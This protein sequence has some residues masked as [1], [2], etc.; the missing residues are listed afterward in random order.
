MEAD[1]DTSFF[2]PDYL[3]TPQVIGA[4]E[5]IEFLCDEFGSENVYLV[6]K[7]SEATAQRSLEWLTYRRFYSETGFARQNVLFCRSREE[8]ARICNQHAL[9]AFIDDRYSVLQHMLEDTR[10]TKLFLF[11]PQQEELT[12]FRA[13]QPNR[14]QLIDHWFWINAHL[15][16]E[17][18]PPPFPLPPRWRLVKDRTE[19]DTMARQFLK[20]TARLSPNS[21]LLG[22]RCIARFQD[23]VLL[24]AGPDEFFISYL[25]WSNE[26][27]FNPSAPLRPYTLA[28]AIDRLKGSAIAFKWPRSGK[29]THCGRSGIMRRHFVTLF[30]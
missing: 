28:E 13:A 21:D 14:I 16:F 15:T 26:P 22:L 24:Q 6:S 8:K 2:G 12:L 3:Y 27:D 5:T 25:T 30:R 17:I 7:C 18:S 19:S 4:F 20:E 29:Q 11:A 9:S 1:T 23:E 10:L